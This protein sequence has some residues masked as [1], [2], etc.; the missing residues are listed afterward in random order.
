MHHHNIQYTSLP[1]Y[2]Y[3]TNPQEAPVLNFQNNDHTEWYCTASQQPID[4][5]M[6][7]IHCLMNVEIIW[8][9]VYVWA[10]VHGVLASLCQGS[11]HSTFT[12]ACLWIL[13]RILQAEAH[14]VPYANQT[15]Q[16]TFTGMPAKFMVRQLSEIGN[17]GNFPLD[18]NDTCINLGQSGAIAKRL[19]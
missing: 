6:F 19:V 18:D 16:W 14:Q 17:W 2:Q 15:S 10:T 5:K 7:I 9:C 13:V 12:T 1:G 4:H 11:N 3:P 8:L